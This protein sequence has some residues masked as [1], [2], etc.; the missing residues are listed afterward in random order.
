MR[1]AL[2]IGALV[3]VTALA[4][5]A[6]DTTD[7]ST[8][9]TPPSTPTAA[10]TSEA[11]PPPAATQAT[12]SATKS[13]P[14]VLSVDEA[15][16]R[17][18]D[19]VR[20]YNEALEKLEQAIN[21]GEPLATQTAVAADVAAELENEIAHLRSTAWPTEIRIPVD[22]LVAVSEKALEQWQQ[23]AD[24]QT[25]DDLIDAAL[26]AAEFDGTDAATTIREH[27]GIDPYD[28]SDY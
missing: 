3:A 9:A 11:T 27:L 8:V 12:P 15:A 20:P 5:C 16:E 7:A 2:T 23:A 17:Y 13:T 25:P 21:G 14:A 10:G 18:L 19:I 1:A 4:G 26:A 24:A 22:D 28:E 6:S